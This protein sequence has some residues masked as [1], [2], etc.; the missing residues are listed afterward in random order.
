M[1]EREL[2]R[3]YRAEHVRQALAADPL[4]S[5][6]GLEVEIG[7]GVVWVRGRVANDD[8]R[9]AALEV[10]RAACAECDVRDGLEIVNVAPEP[11]EELLT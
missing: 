9:R 10:V 5:E 6:L 8:R 2:P 7:D 3:A 11:D 4:V 1:D